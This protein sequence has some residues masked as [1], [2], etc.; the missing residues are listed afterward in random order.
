LQPEPASGKGLAGLEDTVSRPADIAGD[1]PPTKE[2]WRNILVLTW[3]CALELT[4]AS[5][6][7]IVTMAMVSPL[8]K[9]V[10]SAVGIT[11]QPIMIPQILLQAFAVGGTALVA[12]S[13]GQENPTA[14]RG[15]SE[16]TMFLSIGAGL[17]AG[18]IMYY[19][20]GTFIR[21]MG[22]T[23][24]YYYLGEMYM[25]YCAVGGIFQSISA[26]ISA[27]LRGEGRTR[28]SMYFSVVANIV[29]IV[30]GYAL[31]YGIGSFPAMG[32]LGA[33]WAQLV[34]KFVGFLF[35]L[36]I[37]FF[38][39]GLSIKPRLKHIFIPESGI[40]SRICRVGVSSALEQVVMRGGVMLFTV[41]IV[42][43]GTAEF[44]AHNI[45]ATIHIFVVNFGM[46]ISMALVSLVGQ[47]LGMERPDIAERYFTESSKICL[48]CSLILMVPLLLFPRNIALIF[49]Q[50]E[51]V[52]ANIVIVLRILS[53]FAFAQI[54]QINVCGGL[55][56]GGDTRWP[57]YSTM[58]GVLVMRMIMGYFF[59]VV[60]KWG[61]AGAWWCWFLDQVARAL[62]IHYR[63]KS[64]KWKTIKI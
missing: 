58:G 10:V 47:N 3:P 40:I 16:Q 29:N 59:I 4:L 51:D 61:L 27:L 20:G 5:L 56:G 50:E 30:V 36:G 22:A 41:Y 57:L 37:L 52:V 34:G 24:D 55:R 7:G 46:A 64:G 62:I 48:I 53:S 39:R 17:L 42:H 45:A 12:R 28:L 15:A 63:F 54:Y 6:I 18:L 13:I 9:E 33:A 35:A 43:L 21:W 2:L 32:L 1:M 60:F 38:S 44:A 23:D 8:G 11:T 49:T 26:A 31:I 25:R 19:F 14:V